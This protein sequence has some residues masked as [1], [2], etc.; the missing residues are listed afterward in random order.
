MGARIPP[1]TKS[2]VIQKWMSAVPR[3]TIAQENGLSEGSVSGIIA[4]WRLMV[5]SDLADQLR[6]LAIALR[7][8]SLKPVE[9]ATALR[10]V[11]IM[12]RLGVNDDSLEN[13]ISEIYLRCIEI[14][15]DP[16]IISTYLAELVTFWPARIG[17]KEEM[18]GLKQ[19]KIEGYADREDSLV[20]GPFSEILSYIRK[21]KEEKVQ[22]ESEVYNLR[23]DVMNLNS[24]K[25]E[26]ETQLKK[27]LDENQITE[28][29]LNWYVDVKSELKGSGM[30]VADV[31]EFVSAVKWVKENK[32]NLVQVIK[33]F[34]SSQILFRQVINL[35]DR[36]GQLERV[37]TEME[38]AINGKRLKLSEIENLKTLGFGLKELKLLHRTLGEIY[39]THDLASTHESTVKRFMADIENDYVPL[40][41]FKAK[42]GELKNEYKRLN[43]ERNRLIVRIDSIPFLGSTLS[44]LFRKGLTEVDIL[45]IAS[46]F[47]NY[48]DFLDVWSSF[49]AE[50]EMTKGNDE[51]KAN[52]EADITDEKL[53][54]Q[55]KKENNDRNEAANHCL[56]EK[57]RSETDK[58]KISADSKLDKVEIDNAEK[59]V[60]TYLQYLYRNIGIATSLYDTNQSESRLKTAEVNVGEVGRLFVG[61]NQNRQVDEDNIACQVKAGEYSSFAKGN[62][63]LH[64]KTYS[65]RQRTNLRPPSL[66][67][68]YARIKEKVS[69]TSS[70]NPGSC[71]NFGTQIDHLIHSVNQNGRDSVQSISFSTEQLNKRASRSF[72]NTEAVDDKL[73][74]VLSE[75]EGADICHPSNE[76]VSKPLLGNNWQAGQPEETWSVTQL[77][78]ES[79]TKPLLWQFSETG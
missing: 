39:E 61:N 67:R 54:E 48:P 15:L 51:L 20:Y 56:Q 27:R 68:S 30:E 11:N 16:K 77:V 1:S 28:K 59:D 78:Y 22:L 34:P 71:I 10:I 64:F 2:V 44:A 76:G 33:Q 75:A 26:A 73:D 21:L 45:Q 9:C 46:L 4:D 8:R 14:G 18:V 50:R 66:K 5:G 62:K 6:E 63:N 38:N 52:G 37:E 79:I 12:E 72:I 57:Y 24:K 31:K 32:V 41:G 42:I 65:G 23:T 17:N 60:F 43:E 3:D 70:Q 58:E 13:F 40:V 55:P 35:Q 19:E 69:N 25:T 29:H 7:K 36:I 47:H 53:H 74:T 49:K